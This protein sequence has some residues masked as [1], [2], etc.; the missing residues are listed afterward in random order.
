MDRKKSVFIIFFSLFLIGTIYTQESGFDEICRIYT[1]A[2]NSSLTKQQLA[3]YLN[4]NV[5]QRVRDK[6]ALDLHDVIPQVTPSKRYNI[7]KKSVEMALKSKWNCAAI[8][9][10]MK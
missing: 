10:L 4:D 9:V 6:D 7:F 8:K 2:K 3:D 1:E 5:A